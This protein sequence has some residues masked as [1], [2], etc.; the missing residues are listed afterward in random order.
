MAMKTAAAF[1]CLSLAAACSHATLPGTNIPAND[2]TRG[3]LAT[4]TRYHDALEA[5]DPAALLALAAP[6]YYDTGDATRGIPPT[7]NASLQKKLQH[8]F[9]KVNGLRLEATLKNIEVEGDKAHLD[10]FQ[11][12]RYAIT[13]PNGETWRSESDDARMRFVRVAGTWKIASGL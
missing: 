7:D 6:S 1:A 12:I 5:R 4:F 2:D 9:D 13:T 11:V 10:Y 3:V 8:D